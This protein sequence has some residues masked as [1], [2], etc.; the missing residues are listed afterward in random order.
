MDAETLAREIRAALLNHDDPNK[1]VTVLVECVTRQLNTLI[2][3][4]DPG[5]PLDTVKR[6]EDTNEWVVT[7]EECPWAEE[8]CEAANTFERLTCLDADTLEPIR[9]LTDDEPS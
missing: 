1:P 2:D 4:L 8:Y 5:E 3:H 7:D 9:Q 6:D